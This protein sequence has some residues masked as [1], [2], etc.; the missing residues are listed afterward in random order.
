MIRVDEGRYPGEE[1]CQTG[2]EER[3]GVVRVEDVGPQPPEVLQGTPRRQ[4][5]GL[6]RRCEVEDRDARAL[7]IFG[8]RAPPA[9]AEDGDVVPRRIEGG[10]E[11]H[12]DPGEPA[13]PEVVRDLE[14]TD[15]AA[16]SHG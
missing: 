7:E 12:D 8:Q 1:P 9:H 14:D 5:V 15:A 16:G 3:L 6:S 11:R 2:L 13:D 4:A 10:G